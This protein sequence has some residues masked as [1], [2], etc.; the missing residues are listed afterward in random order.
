[1]AEYLEIEINNLRSILKINFELNLEPGLYALTGRNACGKSTVMAALASIFYRDIARSYFFNATDES[2]I[3]KFSL[4]DQSL[5]IVPDTP[6]W[7]YYYSKSHLKL[8][9]FYEGSI[10]HGNRF[11]DANTRALF[12]A[13]RVR[14]DS[15]LLADDFVSTNLG[16]ILHDNPKFYKNRLFRYQVDYA[17]R[18][19]KFRGSPYFI[20]LENGKL[21]SQFSLSTGENMLISVLHSIQYQLRRS[22]DYREK[23]L[24]LL[25]EVELAL[26]PS[27]LNRLVVFLA[28]L[29]KERSL[30]VYFSTHSVELVRQLNAE[31]IYFL[32]KHLDNVVE[33]QN[34]CSPA[35]ATRSIYIHDGYDLLIIVEDILAKKL[36]EWVLI[37]NELKLKKLIHTITG[38]GWDNVV[39]LH[40]DIISSNIIRSGQQVISVLD[41]DIKEEFRK[42]YSDSGLHG[43]L[44][45][46]F[47]PIE[48]A[49]KYLR[50][51][52]VDNVDFDFYNNFGDTFFRLKTLDDLL[53]EYQSVDGKRNDKSGKKLLSILKREL[54]RVGQNE[55]EFYTFLTEYIVE[56]EKEKMNSLA[57]RIKNYIR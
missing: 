3:I 50:E 1:M 37:K 16:V 31:N 11:R 29:A 30:A 32:K 28:Q 45:I 38:G 43:N 36:I 6:K 8:N 5:E 15:L 18:E 7:R 33:V 40:Q 42:K 55:S 34:P 39:S 53:L 13:T 9:G 26:H 44:N 4:E 20:K 52:L 25:D 56:K 2:T 10:I 27:A 17:K 19:F 51:K 23:Y 46:Y 41:G 14:E 54:L 35:Y 24:V 21:I 49:E 48:S 12:E 47:L 57:D 22:K